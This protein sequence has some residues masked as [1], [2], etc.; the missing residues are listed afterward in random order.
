MVRM[1]RGIVFALAACSDGSVRPDAWSSPD[2]AND[3]AA[4]ADA[5]QDAG[6]AAQDAAEAVDDGLVVVLYKAQRPSGE[7]CLSRDTNDQFSISPGDPLVLRSYDTNGTMVAGGYV[8]FARLFHRDQGYWT[9]AAQNAP[10]ATFSVLDPDNTGTTIDPFTY[11]RI[12]T[13][14]APGTVHVIGHY[15]GRKSSPAAGTLTIVDGVLQSIAINPA[16]NGSFGSPSFGP[17]PMYMPKG[18]LFPAE[19]IGT[20]SSGTF[21][22]SA[23]TTLTSSS[24]NVDISL[25]GAA[26]YGDEPGDATVTATVGSVSDTI[27][28]HVGPAEVAEVDL[29]P[30]FSTIAASGSVQLAMWARYTD[31]T[32]RDV[33]G[34]SG[35]EWSV[36]RGPLA[37]TS[38]GLVTAPGAMSGDS[39]EILGCYASVYRD[40]QNVVHTDQRMCSDQRL[41]DPHATYHPEFPIVWNARIT[42]E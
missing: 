26:V 28:V 11:G 42:I 7:N 19:V 33:T 4:V 3:V 5:A 30:S 10:S 35:T 29:K 18:R 9:D 21:C 12:V 6:D 36:A 8:T 32:E 1:R 15:A 22:V 31:N 34:E 14:S 37:V 41:S 16:D 25:L 39:G 24:S 2:V 40:P 13:G 20:F 38:A 17:D 27:D 23:N